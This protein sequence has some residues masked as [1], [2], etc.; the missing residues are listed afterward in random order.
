MRIRERSFA[1][2]GECAGPIPKWS[3]LAD[4]FRPCP[5][6]SVIMQVINVLILL[7]TVSLCVSTMP[8]FNPEKTLDTFGRT[9]NTDTLAML[10]CDVH[11]QHAAHSNGWATLV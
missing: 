6:A 9:I 1:L 7:S 5:Q 3:T 8:A 11:S 10:W 4:M 2:V